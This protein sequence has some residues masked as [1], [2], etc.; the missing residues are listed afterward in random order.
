MKVVVGA[1]R[2]GPITAKLKNLGITEI[3]HIPCRKAAAQKNL[4]IPATAVLIL[5]LVDFLNHNSM[6][7]A[8]LGCS[9]RFIMSRDRRCLMSGN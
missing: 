5:V 2:L 4:H 3:A 8:K 1:D 7:L 9:R 6:K